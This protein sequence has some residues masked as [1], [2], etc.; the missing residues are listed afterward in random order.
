MIAW[1]VTPVTTTPAN[2]SDIDHVADLLHGKEEHVYAD[3]GYRGAA[4]RHR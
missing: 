2:E 4:P 3:S 1:K